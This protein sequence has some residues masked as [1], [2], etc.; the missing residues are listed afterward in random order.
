MSKNILGV[1]VGIK[2]LALCIIEYDEYNDKI[3]VDNNKWKIIDLTEREQKKCCG[4]LKNKNICGASGKFCAIIDGKTYYYC[5]LHKSQHVINIQ[6]IENECIKLSSDEILTNCQYRSSRQ[7]KLCPKKSIYKINDC[8]CCS[9]HRQ[10]IINNI[11]KARS[12][13]PVKNTN[14]ASI[15]QQSLCSLVYEKFDRLDYLQNIHK[16]RIENQ[17]VLKSPTMKSFAVMIFSYFVFLSKIHNKNIDI[18]FA[19]AG[20]KIKLSKE[21][22]HLANEYIGKHEKDNANNNKSKCGCRTCKLK[23]ELQKNVN[24]FNESYNEYKFNYDSTKELGIVYTMKI[25]I[26]ND[27]KE[28]LE[29]LSTHAKKD[30]L[31]DAFLHA[32]RNV[33]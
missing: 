9:I 3:T 24:E 4:I 23:I 10:S 26:D 2:N 21:L 20:A 27:M 22:V 8:E 11:F 12:L 25:F 15:N 28:N 17:P 18:G 5:G 16:V 33:K 32:Y 29:Y 31:C 1:D 6:D 19:S 14:C 7:K 13:K 30:D